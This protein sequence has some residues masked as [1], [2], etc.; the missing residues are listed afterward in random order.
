[1]TDGGELQAAWLGPLS[2]GEAGRPL[3]FHPVEAEA[4]ALPKWRDDPV[5]EPS[6]PPLSLA[7]LAKMVVDR[8]GLKPGD[9]RLVASFN[10]PLAGMEVDPVASQA[11]RSAVLVVAHLRFAPRG[12]PQADHGS[13]Q[14]DPAQLRDQLEQAEPGP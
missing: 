13:R 10:E 12:D 2:P 8:N 5:A 3:E 1:M 7:K 6:I 11:A 14:E 4:A 9:V